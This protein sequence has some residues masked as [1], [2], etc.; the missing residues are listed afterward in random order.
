MEGDT[1]KDSSGTGPW[2]VAYHHQM[3]LALHYTIKCRDDP[4]YFVE[5]RVLHVF[6]LTCD[7][8]IVVFMA[9]VTYG[10]VGWTLE[11]KVGQDNMR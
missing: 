7:D 8:T 2:F 10:I 5:M 3:R 6:I 1:I 4:T 11:A 9:V